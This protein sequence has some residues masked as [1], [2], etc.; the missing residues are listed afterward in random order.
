MAYYRGRVFRHPDYIKYLE[1]VIPEVATFT[2]AFVS[3]WKEGFHPLIGKGGVMTYP[4]IYSEQAI[5]RVHLEPPVKPLEPYSSTAE[6]WM[7]WGLQDETL[8]VF[9]TSNKFL[10]FCVDENREACLLGYLDGDDRDSH[11]VIKDPNFRKNMKA[12]ADSFFRSMGTE[13]MSPELYNGERLFGDEWIKDHGD[14][15]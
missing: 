14:D 5:G 11:Q 15:R 10:M 7:R 9:P 3:F 12:R 13:P 1:D 2:K 8:F 4:D 6:C